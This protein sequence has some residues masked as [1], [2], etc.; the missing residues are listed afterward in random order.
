MFAASVAGLEVLG[1]VMPVF[2]WRRALVILTVNLFLAG[3]L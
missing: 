2:G 3:F 1:E